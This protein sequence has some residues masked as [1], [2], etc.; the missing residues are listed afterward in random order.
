MRLLSVLLVLLLNGCSSQGKP[1][2]PYDDWGIAAF[3][4][5]YMDVWIESVDVIDQQGLVFKRVYG[6]IG[7]T[8]EAPFKDSKPTG[9]TTRPGG[10][11]KPVSGADLP[12]FIFVRWQS[13]VEPQTYN[14]RI[15]IPESARKEMVK[16]I[17]VPDCSRK[18]KR[19]MV[20]YRRDVTIGLAPGGI[21]KVWLTG[22]CLKAIEITRI[23]GAVSKDGPELGQN[24]GRYAYPITPESKAYIDKFGIP[25]G[26]W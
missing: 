8:G 14:V 2:L 17:E 24:N 1:N 25:Y 22:G 12:E 23:K 19:P 26:S 15:N 5:K 18:D 11:S 7:S 4:P 21:A 10:S 16:P 13:L 3:Y 9:W 20:D 6:G